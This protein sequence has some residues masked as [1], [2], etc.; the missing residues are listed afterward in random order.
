MKQTISRLLERYE[1]GSLSR[2][3]VVQ[4][5][6]L[7]VASSGKASA[8]G[9][10]NAGIN[11]VSLYVSDLQRSAEFYSRVLASPTTAGQNRGGTV[12][13]NFKQNYIQLVR[14]TPPGKID[15]I[16]IGVDNFDKDSVV[17]DLRARGATPITEAGSGLGPVH[18]MDPDGFPVQLLRNDLPRR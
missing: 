16:G 15:H 3:D 14:G 17:R 13:I 2:R 18:V 7:L 10:E 5:L 11:H 9:F 4:A 6:A 8:A 1:D 12:A